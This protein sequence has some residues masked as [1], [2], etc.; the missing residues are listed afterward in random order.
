MMITITLDSP[1]DPTDLMYNLRLSV[2]ACFQDEGRD[3]E[4][5]FEYNYI[6]LQ[7]ISFGWVDW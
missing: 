5:R 4:S 3:D 1:N 2:T 6:W 7:I